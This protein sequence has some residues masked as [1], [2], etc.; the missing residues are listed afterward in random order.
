MINYLKSLLATALGTSAGCALV[1][2]TALALLH[3]QPS[4]T[5][6][7][8]IQNIG[9]NHNVKQI[10]ELQAEI[11]EMRRAHL[12]LA[13]K[14]QELEDRLNKCSCS[15]LSAQEQSNLPTPVAVDQ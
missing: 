2:L 1:V 4:P 13:F 3:A 12:N 14:Y 11:L 15:A 9:Q 10:R 7:Q 5:P 8:I 6:Q